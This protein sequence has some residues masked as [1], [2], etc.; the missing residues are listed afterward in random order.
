ME[1]MVELV[2]GNKGVV[3]IAK[4]KEDTKENCVNV[5]HGITSCV[6][7]A[8]AEFCQ[9]IRPQLFLLDRSQSADYLHEDN[10]FSMSDVKRVLASHEQKLFSA[11]LENDN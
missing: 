7:E 3:V 9:S 4:S 6:M 1:C 11:L 5:L 2:N 10:L 8:K